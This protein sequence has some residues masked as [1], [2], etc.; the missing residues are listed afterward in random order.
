MTEVRATNITWHEGH[1]TREERGS[2]AQA[3]GGDALVHRPVAAPA[4]APSPSRWST[5]WCSAATWPT[6]STA[7][8][9]A[10]A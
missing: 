2:A 3:E 8:T 1:V 5:P 10:T 6:C 9:S 7:T 4:R